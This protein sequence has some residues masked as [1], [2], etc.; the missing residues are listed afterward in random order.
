MVL[1]CNCY[2]VIWVLYRVVCGRFHGVSW[3]CYGVLLG[4]M[5]CYGELWGSDIKSFLCLFCVFLVSSCVF[6]VSLDFFCLL[7]LLL[8]CCGDGIRMLYGCV[9]GCYQGVLGV[10]WG[11]YWGIIGVLWGRVNEM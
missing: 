6:F 1:L 7:I 5:G 3:G 9:I 10:L 2:G 4:I 11:C 8:R